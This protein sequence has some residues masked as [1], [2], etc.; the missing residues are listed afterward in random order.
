MRSFDRSRRKTVLPRSIYKE[1][2][3]Y[4][5]TPV[6]LAGLKQRRVI[7]PRSHPGFADN[8]VSLR[9]HNLDLPAELSKRTRFA[10]ITLPAQQVI[11]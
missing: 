8:G 1:N 5:D 4:L 3:D 2:V 6:G 10:A 11:D 7:G 9:P